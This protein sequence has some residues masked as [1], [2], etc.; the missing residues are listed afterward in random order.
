MTHDRRP[1]DGRS[2]V[3]IPPPPVPA[4]S[5][6]VDDHVVTPYP[7]GIGHQP[8]DGLDAGVDTE[9]LSSSS[10]GV[11]P[12]KAGAEVTSETGGA[13]EEPAPDDAGNR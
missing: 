8:T 3:E 2:E 6:A 5:G 10:Q 4:G 7:R 1:A 9:H 12:E 11:R 13:P